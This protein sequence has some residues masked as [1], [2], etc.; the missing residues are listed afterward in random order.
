M[1]ICFLLTEVFQIDIF[2]ALIGN[3]TGI[4]CVVVFMLGCLGWTIWSLLH[5]VVKQ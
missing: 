1:D 3:P 4:L 5:A 2:A